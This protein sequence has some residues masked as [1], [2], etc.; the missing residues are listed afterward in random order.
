MILKRYGTALHSV[1]LNFDANALN[2]IGCRRDR[3]LSIPV[4]EFESLWER[5]EEYALDGSEEGWVQGEV[6]Q[7]MLD[8][9]IAD[10][11]RIVAAMAEGE[12]LLVES[13]Q[14]VDYPKARGSQ[15]VVVEAGENRKYFRSWVEPSLRVGRYRKK[16]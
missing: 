10:I 16:A 4:D 14:G 7:K 13:E 12:V 11:D 9:L 3:Q 15:K 6:E 1:E 2:E 5:V 8:H